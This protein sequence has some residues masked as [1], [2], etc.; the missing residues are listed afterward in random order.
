MS[1]AGHGR[2]E[3]VHV[4]I[5]TVAFDCEGVERA[6]AVASG[7]KIGKGR[8]RIARL[9]VGLAV[10]VLGFDKGDV[11]VL[12]GGAYKD[13]CGDRFVVRDSDKVADVDVLPED[14]LPVYVGS[15]AVMVELDG[16][17]GE[18]GR[19]GVG[20]GTGAFRDDA[21]DKGASLCAGEVVIGPAWARE[22]P[23]GGVVDAAVRLVALDVFVRV[24]D[25]GDSEDDDD[26]EEDEAGRDGGE[27]WEEL[28]DG[29]E[30]EEAGGGEGG[31]RGGG[32]HVHVGNAA[33]LLEEVAGEKGDYGVL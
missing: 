1:V 15:G 29:Y 33:E 7:A 18:C 31:T 20:L 13:V 19:L 17:V 22:D 21:P 5:G 25:G 23:D 24:L 30:E 26:G 28:E 32:V 16:G 2:V 27:L 14:A 10:E 8:G 6:G 9:E 3:L 12:G 4:G 11:L